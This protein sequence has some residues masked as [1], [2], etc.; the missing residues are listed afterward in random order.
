MTNSIRV[1]GC[2]KSLPPVSTLSACHRGTEKLSCT[3]MISVLGRK[4][5]CPEPASS[6][7]A[8]NSHGWTHRTCTTWKPSVERSRARNRCDIGDVS[9][10]QSVAVPPL[11]NTTVPRG[12]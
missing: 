6:P 4:A 5:R 12:V 2:E 7:D 9:L 1:D 8:A 11:K 3:Q 10:H